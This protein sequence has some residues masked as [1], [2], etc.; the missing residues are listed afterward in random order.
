MKVREVPFTAGVSFTNLTHRSG[1]TVGGVWVGVGTVVEPIY[2]SSGRIMVVLIG[3]GLFTCTQRY[4]SK[5]SLQWRP[6]PYI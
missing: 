4:H 2:T 6:L 5:N 1:S 3:E